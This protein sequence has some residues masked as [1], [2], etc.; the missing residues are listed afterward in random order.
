MPGPPGVGEMYVSARYSA[1]HHDIYVWTWFAS[2]DDH[3]ATRLAASDRFTADRR[4]G[5]SGYTAAA[6]PCLPF[7]D[8]TFSKCAVTC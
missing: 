2:I 5:G 4:D 8:H 1:E 7:R 3:R 6:L